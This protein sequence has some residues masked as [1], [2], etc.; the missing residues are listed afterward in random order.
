M[1]KQYNGE[2]LIKHSRYYDYYK[3][4][5]YSMQVNIIEH[6]D[7]L[8]SENR[9]YCDNGNYNH[10][11]NIFTS[12][13]LYEQLQKK[14][15]KEESFQILSHHMWQYV[16]KNS[17]IFRNLEKIPYF[18]WI[19]GILLPYLFNWG[20]GYG[21]HYQWHNDLSNNNILK[22]ECTQCIYQQIFKKYDLEELG[23]MFCFVDDIN[24]GDL[25]NINFTRQHT[26]CKDGENCD[27]LF[28]RK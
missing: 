15:S 12:I 5:D 8:I 4:I 22:F 13:A 1:K 2:R 18:L 16:E 14:Y 21:W 27:F 17:M 3:K 24:Y 23:P 28:I 19:M 20:S 11:S 9:E 6:I 10:L 7:I 25:K 26:L